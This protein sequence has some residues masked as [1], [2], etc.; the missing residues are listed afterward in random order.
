MKCNKCKQCISITGSQA[1]EE[2]ANIAVRAGW[3]ILRLK[4]KSIAFCPDCWETVVMEVPAFK[5][6]WENL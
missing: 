3:Q 6:L 1:I 4:N 5:D 2:A